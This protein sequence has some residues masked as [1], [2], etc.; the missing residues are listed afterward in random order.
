MTTY[1]TKDGD[2][3][4]AICLAQYGRTDVLVQV[5]EANRGL[6]DLGPQLPAG[7]SIRLPDVPEAEAETVVRLWD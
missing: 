3:V 2:M 7:V 1:L 6:A 4:D 5:L